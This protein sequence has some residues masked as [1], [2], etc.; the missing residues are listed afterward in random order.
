VNIFKRLSMYPRTHVDV[1]EEQEA[2]VKV[3]I[4][5]RSTVC[6][7]RKAPPRQKSITSGSYIKNM[8]NAN[9]KKQQVVVVH[10]IKTEIM[11]LVLAG[12]DFR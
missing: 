11:D 3:H 7:A 10:Y 5:C 4:S 8:V 12:I 6:V 2:S 9:R 1:K